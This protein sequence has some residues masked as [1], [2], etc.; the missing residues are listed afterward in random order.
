M[1]KHMAMDENILQGT[2]YFNNTKNVEVMFKKKDGTQVYF[3]KAPKIILTASDETTKPAFK[4]SYIKEGN[5]F[6]GVRIKM[7]SKWTGDMDWI[8]MEGI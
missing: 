5:R 3:T 6:S 7:T 4:Q 2:V 1:P 8:V